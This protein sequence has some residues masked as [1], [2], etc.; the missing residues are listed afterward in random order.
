M[1]QNERAHF[2][3]H[4]P[5]KLQIQ[6]VE[7]K[8][9]TNSYC[10]YCCNF[11]FKASMTAEKS[12]SLSPWDLAT[13]YS[14]FAAA[15]IGVDWDTDSA[16]PRASLRSCQPI[17]ALFRKQKTCNVWRHYLLFIFT[18]QSRSLFPHTEVLPKVLDSETSKIFLIELTQRFEHA[19]S[20]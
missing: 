1:S 12:W 10:N 3:N 9:Q 4:H 15:A 8:V 19:T 5:H 17:Q 6:L 7:K 11:D 16:K 2:S 13:L 20:I 14:S 18:T